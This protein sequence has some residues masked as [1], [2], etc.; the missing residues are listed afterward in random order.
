[1]WTN[2]RILV[3]TALMALI[4]MTVWRLPEAIGFAAQRTGELVFVM[5]AAASI[6]YLLRPSAR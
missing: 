2:R 5:V 6:T 3:L 4:V 1:M